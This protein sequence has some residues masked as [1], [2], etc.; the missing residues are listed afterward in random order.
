VITNDQSAIGQTYL[1]LGKVMQQQVKQIILDYEAEQKTAGEAIEEIWQ[2]TGKSI[3]PCT[4]A[5]Y[6]G[7]QSLDDF[8]DLICMPAL[9]NWQQIDDNTALQLICEIRENICR[10]SIVQRNCEALSKRYGKTEGEVYRIVANEDW[11]PEE[12]LT[13]LKRD[14]RI[15]L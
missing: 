5:D 7:S 3:D 4:L 15:Y 14:T 11:S 6:W 12:A 2:L 13:E 8:V 9:E 10:D 1:I